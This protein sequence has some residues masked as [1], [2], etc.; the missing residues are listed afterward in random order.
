MALIGAVLE[1]R[2]VLLFTTIPDEDRKS[3]EAG[4]DQV[5]SSLKLGK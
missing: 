3:V 1:D 2:T 4:F 5:I